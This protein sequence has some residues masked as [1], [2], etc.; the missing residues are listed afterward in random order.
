MEGIGIGTGKAHTT[1]ARIASRH[2][3]LA[4]EGVRTRWPS[5][6]RRQDMIPERRK[7]SGHDR[8]ASEGI[9]THRT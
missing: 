8:L 5:V 6:G 2:D 9:R 7:A 1:D 3:G 4:S